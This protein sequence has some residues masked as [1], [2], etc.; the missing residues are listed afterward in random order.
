M[1]KLY[2]DYVK[3]I[4][5]KRDALVKKIGEIKEKQLVD[6]SKYYL[7]NEIKDTDND[8]QT[9]TE[10]ADKANRDIRKGYYKDDTLRYMQ[11]LFSF[12]IFIY[13]L[14]FIYSC[15]IL[16]RRNEMKA[17]KKFGLLIGIFMLPLLCTKGLLLIL[18]VIQNFY[19]TFP[20]DV[21]LNVKKFIDPVS[22]LDF[23]K[24]D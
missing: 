21:H 3:P 10:L 22:M 6:Y 19:K 9:T 14:F 15:V 11:Y 18:H 20:K 8:F 2:E 13:T 23:F 4:V 24:L 7:I 5:D 17:T 16:Y 12:L 1:G